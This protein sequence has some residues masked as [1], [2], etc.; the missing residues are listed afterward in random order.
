MKLFILSCLL[1]ASA[2]AQTAVGYGECSGSKVAA[3][4]CHEPIDANLFTY[5][6][7]FETLPDFSESGAPEIGDVFTFYMPWSESIFARQF[8]DDKYNVSREWIFEE[9]NPNA[10]VFGQ[11]VLSDDEYWAELMEFERDITVYFPLNFDDSKPAKVQIIYDGLQNRIPEIV[12]YNDAGAPPDFHENSFYEY[13]QYFMNEGSLPEMVV[14]FIQNAHAINVSARTWEYD[15]MDSQNGYFTFE[16]VLPAILQNEEIKEA[17]PDLAFST[18]PMD[19]SVCGTSTGGA[20]TVLLGHFTDYARRLASTS[21]SLV[22]QIPQGEYPYGAAEYPDVILSSEKKNT[23]VWIEAGVNDY[24]CQQ[25]V[26]Y[27][28]DWCSMANINPDYYDWYL[29][30]NRTAYAYDQ[31]GYDFFYQI[32]GGAG[33]TH[34]SMLHEKFF[35]AMIWVWADDED[36]MVVDDGIL[37]PGQE[38]ENFCDCDGDCSEHS[39]WCKCGLA[40]SCCADS[41]SGSGIGMNGEEYCESGELSKKQCRESS[42]CHWNA[43]GLGPASNWWRGRCW[44]DIGTDTCTDQMSHD[45]EA[46]RIMISNDRSADVTKFFALV[47]I[48]SILS[49]GFKRLF[50][51]TAEEFQPIADNELEI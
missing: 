27:G 32:S 20:A 8:W 35:D 44:S 13:F 25:I 51:K 24:S 29:N 2:L 5:K 40:A 48:A 38:V 34:S 10:G 15:M 23:K 22:M 26:D 46:M 28:V 41:K 4:I 3:G 17:Y 12:K 18:D 49:F 14:V 47:G 1:F 33:S 36:G 19:A 6:D 42:C 21:T 50:S 30:N 37:C 43:W 9:Q 39:D 16:E 11:P 45:T 31:K 7:S